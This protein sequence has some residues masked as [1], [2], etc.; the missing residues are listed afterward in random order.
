[1]GFLPSHS[2]PSH[3]RPEGIL[4]STFTHSYTHSLGVLNW[5]QESNFITVKSGLHREWMGTSQRRGAPVA[6]GQVTSR[7]SVNILG[8]AS[9]SR[10]LN[11]SKGM[12]ST[13]LK[14]V[15]RAHS[16]RHISSAQIFSVRPNL[17]KL[18]PNTIRV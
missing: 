8:A 14:V 5:V 9:A 3:P 16:A 7:L 2:I 12:P 13:M 18:I 17:E 11:T 6:L 10:E 15:Y 4:C 1:M